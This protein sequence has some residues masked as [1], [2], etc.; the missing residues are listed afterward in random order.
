MTH[1]AIRSAGNVLEVWTGKR[2][3]HGRETRD[4]W[5][6]ELKREVRAAFLQLTIPPCS[7][8][9]G[10]YDSTS[11]AP[12][13][14]ENSLFTN[15]S[16]TIPSALFTALRFERGPDNPP[17]APRPI[18]L[19][20]GHLHYY[21]Y[22]VDG[23]WSTW[24]PDQTLAR[25]RHIPRR[26]SVGTDTA[27]PVWFALRQ[28]NAKGLVSVMV[29]DP[30]AAT[31][32]FGIRITVHTTPAGS[33]RPTSNSEFVIDGA[34]AAFHDDPYSEALAAAMAPR[35]PTVTE[36]EFLSATSCLAGPLFSSPAVRISASGTLQISP[37]DERCWLGE[38]A[39]AHDSNSRW[40]EVSGELFTLRPVA[41]STGALSDARI[42]GSP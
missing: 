2:I 13:D 7:L 25:W 17:P 35:L 39:V 8:L 4:E 6:A 22:A 33:H 11:A 16:E 42:A 15:M 20:S 14:T 36:S 40:P 1:Y 34:I 21:R 26:I 38:Y 41:G 18:D 5:Q 30:I 12:G 29:N 19:V 24:E 10:H 28:A 9:A 27:R 3:Q 31:T 37:A 23:S 32:N